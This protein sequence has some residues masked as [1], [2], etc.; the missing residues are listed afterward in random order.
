[1]SCVY[2]AALVSRSML[3]SPRWSS[4]D[5]SKNFGGAMPKLMER[6]GK[7]GNWYANCRH[8]GIKLSDCLETTDALIAERRL[9]ELKILVE[10][11]E[12]KLWKKTFEQCC[13]EYV[14]GFDFNKPNHGRY[15]S[16]V[17]VHLKPH[18][19]KSRIV[20]IIQHDPKSGESPLGD[21]LAQINR[22]P[23]ESAKKI[24]LV[25]QAVIRK[26]DKQFKLPPPEYMN[27]GFRQ[28][29]FMT[30]DELQEVIS[31][32][33][34]QHQP[35]A[36]VMAFT[37]LDLS[38][39]VN[40]KWRNVDF[41]NQVIRV[42]RNKTLQNPESREISIPITDRVMDVLR[43]RN[44]VR[45]LHDDKIFNITGYAFQKAWKRALSKSSVDWHIRVKDLRHFFGSYLLNQE[46][47]DPLLVANLMGHSSVDMLL[48]RYGHF[49]DETKRRVMSLFDKC[50]QNVRMNAGTKQ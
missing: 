11:G 36:L 13:D 40:L 2:G 29:R 27:P 39:A 32:M 35:V 46:G 14:S 4:R 10:R 7:R 50:T 12:Y 22:M 41:R 23:K 42:Y 33:E 45:R 18:F 34:D 24:R 20:E 5:G 37:G 47:V 15:E 30:Q 1:M 38:D 26:G 6:R 48:K 31:Y 28:T 16:I 43:L 19:G 3:K 49:T 21:Y 44:R 17:R 9:A 8:M 25:L